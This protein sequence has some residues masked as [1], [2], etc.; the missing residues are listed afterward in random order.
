MY[1]AYASLVPDEIETHTVHESAA[2]FIWNPKDCGK[3]QV[4]FMRTSTFVGERS[5][6]RQ[7]CAFDDG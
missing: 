7:Y 2:A 5:S 4:T 3:R 6:F 1:T